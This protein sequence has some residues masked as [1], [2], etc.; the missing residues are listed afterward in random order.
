MIRNT[1]RQW[2]SLARQLHWLMAILLAVQ[3]LL[4]KVGHE[5]G[6][7]PERL[8]V[9]TW[10][11]SIGITLLLLV[12]IRL[13]W[14]LFN[15]TPEPPPES[16]RREIWA[17]R[18]GHLALYCL[19]LALPLSGWVMNSAKNMPMNVFWLIPW[20]DIIAPNETIAEFAGETHETLAILLAV[21]VLGHIAAA[22][23]HHFLLGDDVLRRMLRNH[24]D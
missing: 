19:M 24:R 9:L 23:R 12:L 22:L 7:S 21:I 5:L 10:H 15:P 3:F 4:G 2:G 18:A 20:P 16:P 11:K 1:G 17:A 14:R 8:Q 13:S 6:R